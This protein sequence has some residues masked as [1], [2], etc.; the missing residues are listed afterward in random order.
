[1][2]HPN[3]PIVFINPLDEKLNNLDELE[4]PETQQSIIELLRRRAGTGLSRREEAE[5]AFA[6]AISEDNKFPNPEE[7][8]MAKENAKR[9]KDVQLN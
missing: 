9:N 1:M 3:A 8:L 4:I 7:I 5:D 6:L 2:S